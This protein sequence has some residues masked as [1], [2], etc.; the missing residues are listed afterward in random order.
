MLTHCP[1]VNDGMRYR[2]L[3]LTFDQICVDICYILCT[4][5]PIIML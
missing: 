3:K 1:K 2:E 4:G 5:M